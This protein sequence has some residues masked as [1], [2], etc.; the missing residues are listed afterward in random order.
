M[1]GGDTDHGELPRLVSPPANDNLK[2]T[3][4]KYWVLPFGYYFYFA[5]G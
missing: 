4:I 3:H 5:S 1:V 2:C